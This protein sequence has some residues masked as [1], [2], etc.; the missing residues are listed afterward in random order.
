M[1]GLSG[2]IAR[3]ANLSE[4]EKSE[5]V[6]EAQHHLDLA[7]C[8]R[9]HYNSNVKKCEDEWTT[10]DKNNEYEGSMNFS[11][12]YVHSRC[13]IPVMLYNQDHSSLK[14]PENVICLESLVSQ[15]VFK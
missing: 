14:L 13:T 6:I 2:L 3:S 12:D 7:V 5:S 11:F 1:L 10:H 8:Q 9:T 15:L 4:S